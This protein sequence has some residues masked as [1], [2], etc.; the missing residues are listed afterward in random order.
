MKKEKI[1]LMI[2]RNNLYNEVATIILYQFQNEQL[3][4]NGMSS[5][6]SW[7]IKVLRDIAKMCAFVDI[8]KP[9]G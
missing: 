5:E 4:L 7:E 6:L 2:S 8:F 9:C 1:N 3:V